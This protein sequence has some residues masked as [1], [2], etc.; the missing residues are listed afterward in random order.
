M[1]EPDMFE[2]IVV[3]GGAA[4]LSAALF[5]GRACRSVLVLD[6]G[7]PR[8]A[9]ADRMHGFISRDGTPPL[10]LLAAARAELQR[11]PSVVIAQGTLK[12]FPARPGAFDVQ[13]HDGTLQRAA[14]LLLAT[15]VYDA[16][17]NI[18]GLREAWGRTAFVCP[19][20]DGWPRTAAMEPRHSRV[21]ARRAHALR[22]ASTLDE[23]NAMHARPAACG[24]YSFRRRTHHRT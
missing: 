10:D 3:D 11:Y 23:C 6:D 22:R 8:N 13:T 18:E 2:A 1:P 4:G 19:Y 12:R 7:C 20:C 16:Q 5:L 15:G 17:P 9:V 14:Q 21:H 24:T